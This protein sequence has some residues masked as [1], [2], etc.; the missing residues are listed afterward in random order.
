MA[1][2]KG[3]EDDMPEWEREYK[4]AI[5]DIQETY[6]EGRPKEKQIDV[7]FVK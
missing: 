1:E 5:A 2:I 7:S 4:N 3:D 6:N